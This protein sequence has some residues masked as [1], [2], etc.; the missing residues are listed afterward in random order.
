VQEACLKSLI[1]CYGRLNAEEGKKRHHSS[2]YITVI[3]RISYPGNEFKISEKKKKK[4]KSH[5]ASTFP[6]LFQ[7]QQQQDLI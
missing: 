5:Q 3:Q 7:I 2:T 1:I 6:F 4:S